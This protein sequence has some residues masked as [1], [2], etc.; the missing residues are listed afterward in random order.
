MIWNREMECADR[1]TMQALQLERLKKTVA[2]VYAN[3]APLQKE[4]G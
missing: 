2:H 1:D 3:V 4:D